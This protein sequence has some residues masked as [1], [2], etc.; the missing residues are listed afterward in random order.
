[1]SEFSDRYRKIAGQFTV[2]VEG[3]PAGAWDNPAPC[4]GWVARNVVGHLVEWVPGFF[5]ANG[6]DLPK[7]TTVDQDP[8]GAWATLSLNPPIGLGRPTR[9]PGSGFRWTLR[10]NGGVETRCEPLRGR[11]GT[12]RSGRS[13]GGGH[14]RDGPGRPPFCS[15]PQVTSTTPRTLARAVSK[16]AA[17]GQRRGRCS[18]GLRAEWVRRPGIPR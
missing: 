11:G 12:R 10:A 1:M 17:H 16:R 18:V 4:E 14:R 13:G 7:A 15:C 9:R 6:I 5:G 2:R 8:V 3:V